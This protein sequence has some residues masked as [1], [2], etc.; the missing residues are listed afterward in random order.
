MNSDAMVGTYI[1]HYLIPFI[2]RYKDNPYLWSVDACN[3]IE[4]M[5]ENVENGQ[6]PWERLQYFVGRVSAAV[7]QNSQVLVTLGSAAVKWNSAC[8]GCEGNF[9]SDENLQGQYNSPDV[10]LDFYSPHFYGWVVRWFGN[11]AVDRNPESYGLNDRP[12][13]VGENPAKGV[14]KQNTSG[15]DELIVPIEEAYLGAFNNGWRGLMVWTSNG[16]DNNGSLEDCGIGLHNF[17]QQYPELV[18]PIITGWKQ[19]NPLTEILV[20]PNPSPGIIYI[21][22]PEVTDRHL[23]IIDLQGNIITDKDFRGPEINILDIKSF[24]KGM[25]FIKLSSPKSS[26][27][28]KILKY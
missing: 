13:M 19:E 22:D 20:Y 5:H 23:E 21:H 4:W 10:Y 16:V 8:S 9:W 3:E 27:I 15:I 26:R 11:F 12:V 1:D 2:T 24:K 25:Y 18:N 7:H 28:F 17:Y 14:F 6:I